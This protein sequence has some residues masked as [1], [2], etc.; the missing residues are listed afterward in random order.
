MNSIVTI[1]RVP[2]PSADHRSSASQS[3]QASAFTLPTIG[4]RLSEL[5]PLIDFVP[6][7]GPPLIFVLGPWLFVVLM[8]IGPLVLIATLMIVAVIFILVAAA[9]LALPVLLVRRLRRHASGRHT[10]VRPLRV[11]DLH[12]HPHTDVTSNGM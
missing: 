1:N 2:P 8:L 11:P 6:Q 3:V 12:P 10:S 7:A 4:Q 5:V 9:A